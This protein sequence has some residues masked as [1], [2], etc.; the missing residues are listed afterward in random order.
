MLVAKA[1]P[2]SWWSLLPFLLLAAGLLLALLLLRAR[3]T[4]PK[5]LHYAISSVADPQG[6]VSKP[7]PAAHPLRLLF[8]RRA[9]RQIEG[10]RG[11]PLGWVRPEDEA[12]YSLRPAPGVTIAAADGTPMTPERSGA[13]LLGVHRPY[14]LAN[15]EDSLL[16][17][18]QFA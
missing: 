1:P 18:I 15:G 12:L 13:Y 17:R 11:E 4:L 5:D 6:F 7:L 2:L 16:L 8:S 9:E 3:S 10:A 14:R